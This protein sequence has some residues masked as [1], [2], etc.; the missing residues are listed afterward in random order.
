MGQLEHGRYTGNIVFHV[1]IK[2]SVYNPSNGTRITGTIEK[3]NKMGLYMVYDNAIRIL[4]PRDLHLGNEGFDSLN[5]GDKISVEIR[6]SRFQIQDPFILSVAVL[7]DGEA[8]VAAENAAANAVNAA[9][10]AANAVNAVP[11]A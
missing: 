9:N 2:A 6:K 3:K 7:V 4:V 10:A 11:V 8:S 1:Q 5:S